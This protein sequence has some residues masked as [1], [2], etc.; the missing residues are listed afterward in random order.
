MLYFADYKQHKD[1]KIN[2]TLLWEYETEG[3]DFKAMRKIVVQ[4]V[5]ERGWTNDYYA[6]FNL[7]GYRSVRQ[8]VKDIPYL[9][10]KD[11]HFVCQLFNL[12]K[13]ELKCYKNKLSKP[14]HWNS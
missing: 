3:F 12:K 5:L 4:R 6:M 8:T 13:E 9:N 14:Q 10:D 1:C 11:M 2:P 7:Y